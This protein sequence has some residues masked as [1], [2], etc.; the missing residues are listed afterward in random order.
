[1]T[2]E[3]TLLTTELSDLARKV[4]A[5]DVAVERL[6][7]CAG[8]IGIPSPRHADWYT[9]LK[10][11][12]LPQIIERSFMVV[13]VCG[14]T[15]TGKSLLFNQLSGE[16]A[17]GADARAA[18]TK[19]PVCLIPPPSESDHAAPSTPDTLLNRYFE[20]FTAVEWSSPEQP[21]TATEQH[22]LY[23]RIG[24]RVP[25]KL[26]LLDTPDIDSDIVVNWERAAIIRQSADVL[27]AVL[28]PQKYN[29]A[30]IRR[31]FR[32]AAEAGKQTILLWNMI[33][34]DAESNPDTRMIPRWTER[35]ARETGVQPL[36]VYVV[37]HDREA[38]M[39]RTLPIHPYSSDERRGRLEETADLGRMLSGLHFETVKVR[40]LLGAVEK[41]TAPQTGIPAYLDSVRT[42][43]ARFAE[44]RRFLLSMDT[45]KIDWPDLPTSILV[46]EIR[47][48]WNEGRPG[49]SR[50][51]HGT[52]RMIGN[53]ILWPIRK[54]GTY[55]AT[56]P[57]VDPLEQFKADEY[58][59][60][61]KIVEKTIDRIERLAESDNPVLRK[62]LHELLGGE[63]R[64][65]LFEQAKRAHL[66]LEPM[67]ADFRRHLR[68]E[69][70]RWSKD[71]P[72]TLTVIRSLD[73]VTAVARPVITVSLLA[74]GFFGASHLLGQA[75]VQAMEVAITGGI[76]AG[77]EAAVHKTGEGITQSA[78]KLFRE[79]RLEFT[80]RRA[81]H[82]FDWFQREL[83]A[84]T[85][86]RLE[87]GVQIVDSEPFQAVV[88]AMNQLRFS[89]P[90]PHGKQ[91]Q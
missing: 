7:Q 79:I 17:S 74:G 47:G 21:L 59:T 9:L 87:N 42:A 3:E 30:A 62:E 4:L 60:V 91:T 44:A 34:L 75:G 39:N 5:L 70:D 50:K 84:P 18:G 40:A 25:A 32:E 83:W 41:I 66:A 57:A 53:G 23:W 69:L 54:A 63:N 1:M 12:L 65:K 20:R 37:P 56:T 81:K 13:A 67:D 90:S 51:V 64:Q 43:S 2:T 6:E 58:D 16:N 36:A 72:T 35:F 28:T 49:W 78:A 89:A 86:T 19:H 55:L 38:A 76:T 31:F 71:N 29:D 85:T 22:R 11:K 26:M 61:T 73:H 46:E 14:G 15:N 33:D 82:F 88:E 68:K 8:Q 45:M 52:Y 10:Q 77:G 80:Q 27:I 24:R 48:W